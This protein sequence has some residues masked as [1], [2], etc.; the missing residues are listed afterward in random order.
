MS[1]GKMTVLT[2]RLKQA[3]QGYQSAVAIDDKEL[4]KQSLETIF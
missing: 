3:Q 4:Q 2:S 1:S